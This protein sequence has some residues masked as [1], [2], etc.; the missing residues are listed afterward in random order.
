MLR[1]RSASSARR[2]ARVAECASEFARFSVSY[3]S[4]ARWKNSVQPG[5]P[6]YSMSF[7]VSVRSA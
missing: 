5:K 1:S 6:G 3:G 4:S 7:H 2:E